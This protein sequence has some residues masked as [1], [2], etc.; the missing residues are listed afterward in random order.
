MIDYTSQLT[1][2]TNKLTNIENKLSE[3]GKEI[4]AKLEQIISALNNI[5]EDNDTNAYEIKNAIGQVKAWLELIEGN[6]ETQIQIQ[7]DG[8][9][10]FNDFKAQLLKVLNGHYDDLNKQYNDLAALIAKIKDINEQ[11]KTNTDTIIEKLD[12]LKDMFPDLKAAIDNVAS[13]GDT[14]NQ[15]LAAIY[16]ILQSFPNN[17]DMRNY[18][19]AV[20]SAIN[21][22]GTNIES[23]RALLN[24]ID[25]SVKEGTSAQIENA[26]QNTEAILAKLNELGFKVVDGA[27]AIV[28][29]VEKGNLKLDK[30]ISALND[31]KSVVNN[32]GDKGVDIGN[33]IL[34]AIGK[35]GTDGADLGNKILAAINKYGD[36]GINIG[37]KILEAIDKVGGNIATG[38]D[39]VLN[40]IQNNNE[41]GKAIK[42]LLEQVLAN[43][44]TMIKNN[45]QGFVDVINAIKGISVGSGTPDFSKIEALLEAINTGVGNNGTLLKNITEQNDTVIMILKS[46]K[47]EASDKLQTIINK[48]GNLEEDVKAG[49]VLL[50]LI[51]EK[52]NN[53]D[54][55]GSGGCNVDFDKLMDMLNK[56]L[57]AI[58]DHDVH[59]T[60][61]GSGK[62]CCCCGTDKPHEGIIGNLE[63]LLG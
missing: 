63:D 46:F 12:G 61:D 58:Q 54:G 34:A 37:N 28:K 59:V 16:D 41:N 9:N 33:K 47:Q 50:N 23:L 52:I 36:E 10:S 26:K 7:V 6:Q 11:I 51:N 18:M 38:F 45:K 43:Q 19:A 32:Y 44:D 39:A 13:K 5:R 17:Y 62:E 15:L 55:G 35:L 8:F 21:N 40:A 30:V 4:V 49:N 14:A 31:I 60:V 25:N 48:F 56:I 20:I 2:L 27:D 29:A 1:A 42:A 57:K 24:Q 53:I 22:N 3:N